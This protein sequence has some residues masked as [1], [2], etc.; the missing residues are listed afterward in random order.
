MIERGLKVGIHHIPNWQHNPVGV[1]EDL[2]SF[3]KK[4]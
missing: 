4:S 2:D 3:M 1:P